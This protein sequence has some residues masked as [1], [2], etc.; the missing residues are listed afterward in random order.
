MTQNLTTTIIDT[1][2]NTITGLLLDYQSTDPID[3]SVG[4]SAIT[5]NFPGVASVYAICQPTT[6]NP[7]PSITSVLTAPASPSPPTR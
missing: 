6:C 4:N 7:S 2:G 1:N 5:T 3:I